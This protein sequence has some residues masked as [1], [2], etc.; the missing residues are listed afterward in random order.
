[1]NLL[2]TLIPIFYDSDGGSI[3]DRYIWAT[4]IVVNF[5]LVL[6]HSI[7][8]LINKKDH[9]QTIFEWIFAD[10]AFADGP[11]SPTLCLI[12]WNGF[13]LLLFLIFLVAKLFE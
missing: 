7:F 3:P 1:M 5:I 4:F 12:F 13:A 8:L 10:H 6:W 9:T 11:N 2:Q